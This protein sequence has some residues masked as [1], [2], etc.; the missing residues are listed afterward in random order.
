VGVKCK[1]V[2]FCG[3]RKSWIDR[4]SVFFYRAFALT[5][6]QEKHRGVSSHDCDTVLSVPLAAQRQ[7][8]DPT[9]YGGGMEPTSIPT[10][11]KSLV[12]I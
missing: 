4:K 1:S 8:D 3:R 7:S 12:M 5:N 2:T 6:L 10:G 11:A 9:G